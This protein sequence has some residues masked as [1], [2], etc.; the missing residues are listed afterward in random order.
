MINELIGPDLGINVTKAVKGKLEVTAET[1][2][3][4][5]GQCIKHSNHDLIFKSDVRLSFRLFPRGGTYV[6]CDWTF[7]LKH[8]ECYRFESPDRYFLK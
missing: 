4:D 5:I 2:Y 6:G 1:V 7:N 8:S 3:N